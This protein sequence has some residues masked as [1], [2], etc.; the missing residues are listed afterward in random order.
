MKSKVHIPRIPEPYDSGWKRILF[1][2]FFQALDF[3]VPELS[4][5]FDTTVA[6]VFLD[7][8][9]KKIAPGNE[10]GHRNADVLVQVRL[11][12]GIDQVLL[13]HLEL[14]TSVDSTL[15]H[16]T[17]VYAYRIYDKFGNFPLSIL[18]LTDNDPGFRPEIFTLRPTP[19]AGVTLQYVVIK[20]LDYLPRLTELRDSDQVIAQVLRIYL[21]FQQ[22][23]LTLGLPGV[24][25]S[26]VRQWLDVK[27]G[28]MK[29]LL[30]LN[31]DGETVSEILLFL[32]WIVRLPRYM[33]A[34]Y[35]QLQIEALENKEKAMT[36]VN[37]FER[38]ALRQ[39]YEKG[40]EKGLKRGKQLGK[41]EG[42][43]EALQ[44]TIL[45]LLQ[46]DS[47]LP[48]EDIPVITNCKNLETLEKAFALCVD[49]KEVGE[50]LEVLRSL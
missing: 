20:T 28:L 44:E 17:F 15:G 45:R 49:G 11:L 37:T 8:E 10:V 47:P 6:P 29:G 23:R 3:F 43:I 18:L 4:A 50:V 25:L 42:K 14:Q 32:D 21:E 7:K 46:K 16:R 40:L 36:Y 30:E 27:V 34:T 9:L 1:R 31:L 24:S 5:L 39:K 13:C 19:L 26:Q 22:Q 41:N 2:Y 33:E 12:S 38:I 35:D 48:P